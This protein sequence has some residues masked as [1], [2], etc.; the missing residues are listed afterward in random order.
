MDVK[1][2]FL[3]PE[4]WAQ[5]RGGCITHMSM[6]QQDFSGSRS[7]TLKRGGWYPRQT[8]LQPLSPPWEHFL[9]NSRV[10]SLCAVM[11]SLYFWYLINTD[12]LVF[13]GSKLSSSFFF[14]NPDLRVCSL[15]I[16]RNSLISWWFNLHTFLCPFQSHLFQYRFQNMNRFLNLSTPEN[17]QGWVSG[18]TKLRRR[19][20]DIILK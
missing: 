19:I 10:Y 1:G 20:Q 7:Q 6:A 14:F 3:G 17:W 2:K 15:N 12:L 4:I 8:V 9:R 16:G 5:V 18:P 11:L 13:V